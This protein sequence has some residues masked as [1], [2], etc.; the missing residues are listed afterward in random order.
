M[1]RE[2]LENN[3]DAGVQVY[4]VWFSMLRGDSRSGWNGSL[5][6]DPRVTHLWDEER[7]VGRWFAEQEGFYTSVA[8]DIYYLYGQ[9]ASWDRTPSP[10]VSSG[11][12]I[13]SRKD[14][15]RADLLT[16]LDE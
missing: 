15:L 3:P 13:L 2:I 4:A 8:W 9:E 14:R 16:L 7:V 12:T 10:L 1:Q 6:P 11:Y 5:M